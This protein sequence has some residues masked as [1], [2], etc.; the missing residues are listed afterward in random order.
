[1]TNEEA[2]KILQG[3]IKKPNT[4]DGYLGQAIDMAIKALEQ[5]SITWI[6]G[7]DNCQVAVRNMPIDKMQK[8][9][10]VIGEEDQPSYDDCIS[11]EEAIIIAEQGQIQGFEWQFKKLCT[12]PP[13]T[14][15]FTDEEIQ[16]MQELEQAQL[17]KAYEL[18]MQTSF[19]EW[20]SSFNPDSATECFTAVKELKKKLEG[21]IDDAK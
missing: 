20:L 18:G 16:K 19:E 12:L 3:A 2:I 21:D 5:E 10:A 14:P 6:V 4:K 11:R 1:M 15:K 13:V 9:C 8:I 17:E 7:N